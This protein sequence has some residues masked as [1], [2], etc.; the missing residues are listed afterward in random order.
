MFTPYVLHNEPQ[1]LAGFHHLEE[2]N[3][4]KSKLHKR[5][6]AVQ[7]PTTRT[8]EPIVTGTS[9]L[10]I[11]YKDGVMLSADT[12]ASYGS[13]A[14]FRDAERLRK[15][16]DHTLIGGTG[17]YSDFQYIMKTLDELV[18][19]DE[20]TDDGSKLNPHA[21]HSYLTRLMY[22]RRNKM[23]P[24]WGQ[25][26][27]AGFKDGK[28]YLGLTDLRGTC[29]TDENIATGYGNYI[30]RALLRKAPAPE[31]LS[32]EEAK[33]LLEHCMRVQFYRDA[34]AFDRIQIAT[35]TASGVEI[36]APYDISTNWDQGV[37]NYSGWNIK[38]TG[39]INPNPNVNY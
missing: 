23:D 7:E 39:A 37:I 22:N 9:V 6:H 38:N 28:S 36:S 35:V 16:G 20:I 12:L 33:Q 3:I 24:L 10:A 15:L 8:L 1:A 26:V 30:A 18:T 21:I 13:L 27:V 14:R 19:E 17:D 25:I 32:K 2:K 31:S 29:Y 34:R 4:W 5:D 11:K